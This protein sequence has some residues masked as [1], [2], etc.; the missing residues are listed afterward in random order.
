[1]IEKE[2]IINNEFGLHIRVAMQF[3]NV[4]QEYSCEVFV[5]KGNLR[6]NGKSIIGLL[7]LGASK[8]SKI[9]IIVEGKNEE[10]ITKKLI[11]SLTKIEK[12]E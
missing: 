5:E 4:A 7:K 1:M 6:V 11:K 12:D 3:V 9:K 8:G 2:I 10:D